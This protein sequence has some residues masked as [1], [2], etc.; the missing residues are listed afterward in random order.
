MHPTVVSEESSSPV[1]LCLGEI[2]ASQENE[3]TQMR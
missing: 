1:I 3:A 2:F